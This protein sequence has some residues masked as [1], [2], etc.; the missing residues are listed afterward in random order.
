MKDSELKEENNESIVPRKKNEQ[1]KIVT[2]VKDEISF[3]RGVN[4]EAIVNHIKETTDNII[5][6]CSDYDINE[7]K[8]AL[9][10]LI[11]QSKNLLLEVNMFMI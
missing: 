6:F 5:E 2:E 3:A 11:N 8:N 7:R 10:N 9:S 4:K 1:F